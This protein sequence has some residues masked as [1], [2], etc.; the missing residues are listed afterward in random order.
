[1]K[2]KTKKIDGKNVAYIMNDGSMVIYQAD[3][4]K[5]FLTSLGQRIP[6]RCRHQRAHMEAAVDRFNLTNVDTHTTQRKEWLRKNFKSPIPQWA[7]WTVA[8]SCGIAFGAFVA[9]NI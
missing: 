7:E 4:D 5:T 1:M 8:I 2:V 9:L 6:E 3:G